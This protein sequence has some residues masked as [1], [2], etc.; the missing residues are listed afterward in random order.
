VSC[1]LLYL[2]FIVYFCQ[3]APVDIY[4][5]LRVVA[6]KACAFSCCSMSSWFG[7]WRMLGLAHARVASPARQGP[8]IS[9]FPLHL[10]YSLISGTT[11]CSRSSCAFLAPMLEAAV[12]LG[13]AVLVYWKMVF[14]V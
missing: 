13:N 10:E 8:S 12:S 11:K 9:Y 5:I 6:I 4:F 1:F 3:R 2:F 14:V 7:H